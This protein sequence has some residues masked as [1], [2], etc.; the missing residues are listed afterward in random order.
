MEKTPFL[1]VWPELRQYITFNLITGSAAIVILSLLIIQYIR[2]K[3]RAFEL[4]LFLQ[5]CVCDLI[6]T[7]ISMALDI[8]PVFWKVGDDISETLVIM[9][10]FLPDLV[11]LIFAITLLAQWLI[12]VEYTLHQS[13]DLIRRR[14][15]AAFFVFV[16][17]IALMVISIPVLF[18][19][20]APFNNYLLYK[21]LSI[22]SHI[23]LFSFAIAVYVVWF[24]E[25]KRNRIPA[26]IHLTPTML[27]MI[28]GFTINLLLEE[29]FIS[30]YS[31]LPLA[32]ALGLLFADY[33][34]YRR[35]SHIDPDTRLFNSSYLSAVITLA[36]KKKLTGATV[37][38]F[39]VPRAIEKSSAILK[40]WEPELTKTI[41]MGDGLFLLVSEPVKDIVADRFISLLSEQFKNEGIPVDI[42]YETDRDAPL[43]EMLS[44]YL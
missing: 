20:T 36:K 21:I 37:I 38:R 34:Q 28:A 16:A 14:Y 10:F 30:D 39:K 42:S 24:R 18:W 41:N 6:M 32:Y 27:C 31:V 3:H 13:R 15:K 1:E 4:T 2:R 23:I 8:N 22:F 17:G 7:I 26:Y 5:M 9:I 19:W 11:D 35:L 12:Y 43:D 44:K 33:Y 25:R 40:S 29:V